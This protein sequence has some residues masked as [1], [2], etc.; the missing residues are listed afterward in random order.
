MDF[1]ATYVENV[2]KLHK[3]ITLMFLLGKMNVTWAVLAGK[4]WEM[5]FAVINHAMTTKERARTR[6]W[7]INPTRVS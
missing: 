2:E 7:R 4:C 5:P 1:A 3:E 6:S